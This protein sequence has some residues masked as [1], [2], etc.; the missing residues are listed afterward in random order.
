MNTHDGGNVLLSL[1]CNYHYQDIEDSIIEAI[2]EFIE[3]GTQST[4]D[5]N[6]K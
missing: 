4:I 5:R 6:A 3:D 1:L 2:I